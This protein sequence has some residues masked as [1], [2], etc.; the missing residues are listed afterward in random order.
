[1]S[2]STLIVFT[3]CAVGVV[4]G[5]WLLPYRAGQIVAIAGVCSCAIISELVEMWKEN[6]KE[7]Q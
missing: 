1:M 5:A 3:V 7:R 4:S 2:K 6:R